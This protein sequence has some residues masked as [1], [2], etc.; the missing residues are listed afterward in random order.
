MYFISNK[1]SV[2]E[3]FRSRQQNRK[4]KAHKSSVNKT[5]QHT[6]AS[7]TYP[8]SLFNLV[9]PRDASNRQQSGRQITSTMPPHVS[10]QDATARQAQPTFLLTVADISSTL[11]RHTTQRRWY[12]KITKDFILFPSILW[13]WYSANNAIEGCGSV[14]QWESAVTAQDARARTSLSQASGFSRLQMA[15]SG[16]QQTPNGRKLPAS[17]A[18]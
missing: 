13:Q 16:L 14:W 11:P 1:S 15:A 2:F 4:K 6:T 18:K 3:T 12:T 7:Y 10:S 8:A 5:S 9:Y 17:S